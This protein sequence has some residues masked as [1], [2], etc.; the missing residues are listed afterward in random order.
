MKIIKNMI[1]NVKIWNDFPKYET[2]K[3][4]LYR[5]TGANRYSDLPLAT[6]LKKLNKHIETRTA[7]K[8]DSKYD[9]DVNDAN[10]AVS[11]TR[12]AFENAKGEL[13]PLTRDH[14]AEIKKTGERISWLRA[15]IKGCHNAFPDIKS[16]IEDAFS[17]KDKAYSDLKDA[18]WY[19][20]DYHNGWHPFGQP[21][22]SSL[23]RHKDD[24][25]EAG[26][27][28]RKYK[29]RIG[30]LHTKR[31]NLWTE[32]NSN[33]AEIKSCERDIETL[34]VER[35]RVRKLK[36]LKIAL[37]AKVKSTAAK[38]LSAECELTGLK[39]NKIDYIASEKK[40][41]RIFEIES[42]IKELHKGLALYL[43][44]WNEESFKDALHIEHR[45]YWLANNSSGGK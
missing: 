45:E 8:F 21:S 23:E 14:T 26:R 22:Y 1:N 44:A 28:I 38:L 36:T 4:S 10:L 7:E 3:E 12:L 42:S 31:D 24:R 29:N 27:R 9:A 43:E 20:N 25:E 5:A 11:T 34:K 2:R 17:W 18:K 37:R 30:A 6:K 19:I 40:R 33:K 41:L 39:R 15:N 16:D 35:K 13:A 32:I